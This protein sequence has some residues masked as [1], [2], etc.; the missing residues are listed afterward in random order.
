MLAAER[1]PGSAHAVPP[2]DDRLGSSIRVHDGCAQIHKDHGGLDNV[3]HLP[4][5]LNGRLKTLEP[6]AKL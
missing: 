5:V 2:S 3:E 6:M 1:R 4:S